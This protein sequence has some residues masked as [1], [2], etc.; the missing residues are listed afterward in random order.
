MLWNQPY[1]GTLDSYLLAPGLLVAAAARR[2]PRLRGRCAA[3]ARRAV[4]P[5]RRGARRRERAAGP[6]RRSPRW[7]RPTW[8]SWRRPAP[9]PNF[10][11]PLLVAVLAVAR[12]SARPARRHG[13]ARARAR[14]AGNGPR[15]ASWPASSRAWRSGTRRSHSPRSLGA[16]RACSPAGLRPR[17][18]AAALSG[19]CAARRSA[20]ARRARS[21]G[22]SAASPVT[23]LRPRWLWADGLRDLA[24]AGAGLFGLRCR[25]WSTAPSARRCR[26]CCALSLAVGLGLLVAA[27]ARRRRALP[28]VGWAAA[29]A[30]AFAPSRRTGGDEVRYLYGLALPVLV[31]AGAGI[32]RHRTLEP[33]GRRGRWRHRGR[34][35][36]GCSGTARARRA[37]ARSA[38]T[39]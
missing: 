14:P 4:G 37:L 35:S 19:R 30:G 27:G 25:S 12:S 9:P 22:A 13:R 24:R 2:L 36:R 18:R 7:A 6:R 20:A 31:L 23:A 17:P 29:L 11:V 26:S 34:R 38:R 39:R 15:V 10:L 5:A 8:R 33:R 21:L 3:P 16:R 1:N 32:A 28:L